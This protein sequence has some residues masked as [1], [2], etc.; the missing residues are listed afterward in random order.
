[1]TKKETTQ[2]EFHVRSKSRISDR[3]V[4]PKENRKLVTLQFTCVLAVGVRVLFGANSTI[5]TR[6]FSP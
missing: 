3:D 6:W 5:E 4:E 1:M 2:I